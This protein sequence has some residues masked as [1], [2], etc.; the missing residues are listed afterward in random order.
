MEAIFIRQVVKVEARLV[1]N[2]TRGGMSMLPRIV[3]LFGSR[4]LFS[5]DS[6]NVGR[7][8]GGRKSGDGG[9]S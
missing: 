8:D 1:Y 2:A 3:L 9:A 6:L 7:L 5:V 4:A